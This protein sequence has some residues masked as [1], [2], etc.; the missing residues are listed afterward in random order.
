[1]RTPVMSQC[2]AGDGLHNRLGIVQRLAHRETGRGG[3]VGQLVG[4]D[5]GHLLHIVEDIEQGQGQLIAALALYAVAACHSVKRADAAGRPVAAPYSWPCSRST[6]FSCLG[7]SQLGG[8]GT[9]TDT[10]GVSLHDADGEVQLMAR[11]AGA[12]GGVGRHGVG[13]GGVGV[14]AEVDVAQC[15]GAGPRT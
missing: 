10:G 12:D 7:H 4:G 8:E 3:A 13:G 9:L 14:D 11:D 2:Q 15:T 5:D 1:M 6:S